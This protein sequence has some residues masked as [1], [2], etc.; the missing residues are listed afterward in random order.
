MREGEPGTH[1]QNS[2]K[3]DRLQDKKSVKTPINSLCDL[4]ELIVATNICQPWRI[5]LHLQAKNLPGI[6]IRGF[7]STSKFPKCSQH[8]TGA[9]GFRAEGG[10]ALIESVVTF[11]LLITLVV[12]IVNFG[13]IFRTL[14]GV[15]NAANV[16]A[17]YASKSA[18]AATDAPGIEDAVRG[19]SNLGNC[20]TLTVESKIK[21][22]GKVNSSVTVKVRC[23]VGSLLAF[24][25]V[26]SEVTIER[27]VVR[28][29]MP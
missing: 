1:G 6:G 20:T 27:P 21:D 28:R 17:V 12:A 3:L 13:F 11:G 23:T 14:I 10:Q 9:A 4:V 7:M 25:G 26:P 29:I 2:P 5:V 19:E 18:A 22:P 15:T 8:R 24:P 16:G